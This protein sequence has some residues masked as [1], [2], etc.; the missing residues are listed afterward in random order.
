MPSQHTGLKQGYIKDNVGYIPLTRNQ[1]A[2]CDAHWFHILSP[3]N[4]CAWYSHGHWYAARF[5]YLSN[6]HRAW[7]AMHRV[8]TGVTDP[9]IEVDHIDRKN[10]LNN[11]ESNLRIATHGQNQQNRGLDKNNSSGYKGVYWAKRAGKWRALIAV[12]G[13]RIC[14]GS[15]NT[16]VEAAA[17][18]NWAAR[19]F[20]GP[21][22]YQNDLSK[23]SKVTVAQ[24]HQSKAQ[25][26]Q[27][28]IGK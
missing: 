18:W 21:F 5:L 8:V 12:N 9:A 1:W 17:V 26:A 2:L 4:W 11:C 22:A 13:K 6:G 14:L 3:H 25:I 20:H 23:V 7:Q 27:Q 16:A 15:F 10:T 28:G 24:L 19:T